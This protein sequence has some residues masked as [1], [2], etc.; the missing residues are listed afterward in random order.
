VKFKVALLTGSSLSF[1]PRAVKE[2]SAVA[3]A[4]YEV[5]VLGA[6]LDS[7]RKALDLH[8][9]ENIPFE[10]VPTLDFTLPGISNEVARFI[11]RAGKKAA[12]LT[13][14]LTGRQFPLQ[15]GFGI[16]RLFR[17]AKRIDAD[18]YIAHSE[19]SLYVARELLRRGMSVGVDMEDWFSEDLL[20]DARRQRPLGLLQSLEKELLMRG[21][22][23]SCPS[24]A[25]SAALGEAY[26][27]APPTVIYNAFE[28]SD[29]KSLDR[30]VR[31]R[32]SQNIA[33]IH[34]Y[35][36]TLGFG[37]GLEDLVAAVPHLKHDTEIHLR[38]NPAPGVEDWIKTRVPDRWRPNIFFH[39]LVAN[40]QLL[41]R[42]AEHDI[43]FAGEMQYCRSR[44]LTITNKI[45]HYLLGGLAVVASDTTGQRE[46][47]KEAP[48][49]V[50]L[51][52]SGNAH[53]L[54]DVLNEL[55][56][57]PDRMRGAKAAALEAAQ[58]T[59]CWERQEGRLIESVAR[60]LAQ[61]GVGS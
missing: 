45:L 41:S 43:G 54:A 4:G 16:G 50:R 44:D 61:P 10:F 13:Y 56:A 40:D 2:A 25:M 30:I 60:A 20:P 5:H 49:A 24:Q 19:S 23:T 55:L 14:G 26:R 53:A 12:H 58:K 9:I 27:C 8:L 57:S 35:S 46:V 33:S 3:R 29:R 7:T 36:T 39:P 6:W 28:W 42:I 48:E 32:R 37:R 52:R 17:Q 59:F 21:I 15:L 38:G 18:L 22:Y 1:N 34:W 47:A 51:Y 31:D 11:R